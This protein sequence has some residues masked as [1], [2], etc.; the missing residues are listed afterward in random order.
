M[1]EIKTK[2]QFYR[3]WE[4]GLLGNRLQ[5]WR[6]AEDAHAS[7]VPSVGFREIGA[8]GGGRLDIVGRDL[9][10]QTAAEWTAAKRPYMI[11][12][13]APDHRA[14]VQGEVCEVP[15]LGL[16]GMLGYSAGLRMRDAIA[17]GKLLNR[18]LAETRLIVRRYLDE[19]SQDTLERLLREYPGAAVE[20]TCYDI[21]VGAERTNTI[22]WEVRH[23]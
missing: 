4:A 18:G 23:Y 16:R 14:T 20:F 11:C 1:A 21:P 19:R 17:Q 7:G 5:V 6:R 9:I 12:E 2:A 8:A 3:L 10:F 15:G 22:F 13:S